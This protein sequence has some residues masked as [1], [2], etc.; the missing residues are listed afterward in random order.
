VNAG[1]QQAG[2]IEVTDR[3]YS[4]VA[5]AARAACAI[6]RQRPDAGAGSKQ[7]GRTS[8]LKKRSKKL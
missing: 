3:M 4:G 1:L 8:F 6:F 7:K 5:A 2:G